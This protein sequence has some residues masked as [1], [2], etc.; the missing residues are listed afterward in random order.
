MTQIAHATRLTQHRA[1]AKGT[2]L[3]RFVRAYAG[4]QQRR[5]LATLD[6]A[7]LDDIGLTR[8]QTL[9]EASRPMWNAPAQWL[10]QD[11]F[12]CDIPARFDQK[13]EDSTDEILE[14]FGQVTNMIGKASDKGRYWFT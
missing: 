3:A 9:A 5:H 13:C 10:R 8:A 2:A 7:A 6:D 11:R 4:W 14:N 12:T 1:H